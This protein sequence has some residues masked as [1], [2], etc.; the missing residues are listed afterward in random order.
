MSDIILYN[1]SAF[2]N[3]PCTSNNIDIYT[4]ISKWS[5]QDLNNLPAD[6]G[7]PNKFDGSHLRLQQRRPVAERRGI[8]GMLVAYG[9]TQNS[10]GTH[11]KEVCVFALALECGWER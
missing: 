5:T 3:L 4:D 9:C 8:G 6:M 10:Q 7:H 2:K 1:G 11:G